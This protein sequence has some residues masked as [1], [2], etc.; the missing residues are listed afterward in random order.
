MPPPT[1]VVT[2]GDPSG[3]GPAV[4]TEALPAVRE[5]A[6]WV[7]VGDPAWLAPRIE[8]PVLVA[9][10]PSSRESG[11]VTIMP[12]APWPRRVMDTHAPTAEGGELQWQMLRKAAA[13]CLSGGAD[14]VVTG[15]TSKEAIV[16][17]GH[18]FRGQTE[19]L[20]QHASLPDDAVSMLFLGPKLNVGLVT[21]HLAL[22]E[23]PSALSRARICRTIQHLRAAMAASGRGDRIVVC[24]LNPHAGEG[25][26]FGSE[27]ERTIGPAAA[28][29]QVDGPLPA[30]TVFRMVAGGRYDGVVAM[31][32]DQ[33]TI[34]S[35][36]LDFG[37]AVNVTWG[38]PFVRTSV[39]HGVAYDAAAA[40]R[41]D[42]AGMVSALR[43][44]AEL[45]GC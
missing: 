45:A 24:G 19:F 3:V 43:L 4:V 11:A 34:P 5:R 40:G 18:S 28:A 25:G 8:G 39:D 12:S 30:E 36:L 31:Y 35:K 44:G 14:G 37:D 38:L 21:T 17:A 29:E 9:E 6:S 16:A 2:V 23:V 13:L 1:L 27:E 33:A 15:P 10:E 22:S 20:A 41:A 7:V 32:H 42:P 26:L